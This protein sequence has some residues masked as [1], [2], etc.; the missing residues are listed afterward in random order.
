[1]VFGIALIRC[2]SLQ[3]KTTPFVGQYLEAK[4]V[5]ILCFLQ[6]KPFKLLPEDG[7]KNLKY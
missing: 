6:V 7:K 4:T 3:A 2:I 1:L 5:A